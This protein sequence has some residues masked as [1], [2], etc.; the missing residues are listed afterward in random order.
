ML[1]IPGRGARD[2]RRTDS[3]PEDA[4]RFRSQPVQLTDEVLFA[5]V[6]E[7]PGLS[8]PDRSLIT[9][10]AL[11][12]LYRNGQFGVLSGDRAEEAVRLGG[13]QPA[14]PYVHANVCVC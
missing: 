6:W 12:A 10:A 9:V 14:A 2:G 1:E 11:V 4:R 3:C 7:R 13:A 5:D 8:A